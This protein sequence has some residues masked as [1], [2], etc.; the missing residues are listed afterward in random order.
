MA[1]KQRNRS[2]I[3][4]LTIVRERLKERGIYSLEEFE[5]AYDEYYC[6]TEAT[7]G[8]P[9][10]AWYGRKI[11]NTRVLDV[12]HFLGARHYT[13]LMTFKGSMWWDELLTDCSIEDET[14]EIDF[15]DED[16]DDE[17]RNVNFDN[18]RCDDERQTLEQVPIDINWQ[19]LFKGEPEDIFA[20]FLQSDKKITQIAPLN[21]QAC[22]CKITPLTQAIAYPN[23]CPLAFDGSE[24]AGWRRFIVIRTKNLPLPPRDPSNT[25][26]SALE[27]ENFARQLLMQKDN[28]VAVDTYEFELVEIQNNEFN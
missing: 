25:T 24:G 22:I 16:D 26:V 28:K 4:D 19:L 20:A 5:Q 21:A 11:D 17:W 12:A 10:K 3:L 7:S 27:L 18:L 9:R 8:E 13:E 15:I 6:N 23:D 14:F 2:K 1:T